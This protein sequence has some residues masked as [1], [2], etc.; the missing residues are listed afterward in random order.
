MSFGSDEL[1]RYARHLVLHE[2]GGP[3]QQ[4]LK[5]ARV[6]VIGAGGLGCPA[7][8][9]LA[10][11]GVG[12]I[13]V[14]DDDTVSLSNLQRQVLYATAEV[15]RPKAQAAA[16]ALGRLNEHVAVEPV[17][18][19]LDRDNVAAVLR[20]AD[21]VLDGS[22]NADTRYTVNEA[23]I[24]AGIPL[25]AGAIGRWEGQVGV[26][27]SARGGPCYACAFPE[28]PDP[29]LV[30]ACAAAGV[31]GALAGVIGAMQAVE[32]VKVL[33]G[34]GETLAGRLL[35]Y[36]ALRAETRVLRLSRREGCAA[37]GGARL[38]TGM[39]TG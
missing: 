25:V 6:V 21:I 30:P 4:R 10:A 9:Y 23:A 22:D 8:L 14:V 2:I 38:G 36:D 16:A 5:A 39:K 24:A 20:G 7:L 26:F 35:L 31:L 17:A 37:C 32:A 18:V 13:A 28:A 15:G 3:G 29:A 19:R 27:D 34:A 1:E 11:A 33:T 12:R